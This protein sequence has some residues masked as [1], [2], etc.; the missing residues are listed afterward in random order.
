MT[1]RIVSMTL[2]DG[3]P[4]D[5]NKKYNIAFNSFD[6]RSGGHHFMKLRAFLERPEANYV[7]HP[8]QTRDALIDYFQRHKLCTGSPL[9][10]RSK[11]RHKVSP[12]RSCKEK[13]L[14]LAYSAMRLR[15]FCII[16]LRLSVRTRFIANAKNRVTNTVTE[17][18]PAGV[19]AS[20]DRDRTGFA[21]KQN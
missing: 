17:A 20:T 3:R 19:P 6:S 5:R 14:S 12:V 13:Q 7:L 18:D 2:A 8:V 4:L 1:D 16:G 21:D 11:S 9:E 15:I 10:S